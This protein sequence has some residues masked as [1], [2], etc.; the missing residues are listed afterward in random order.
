MCGDAIC[1]GPFEY[2]A[3][4]KAENLHGCAPDCGFREDLS[5]VTVSLDYSAPEENGAH[6]HCPALVTDAG[7]RA[8]L[9]GR[10]PLA[11]ELAFQH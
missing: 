10:E 6:P 4:G 11:R 7:R 1:E 8:A 2:V 9:K 5:P 3:W